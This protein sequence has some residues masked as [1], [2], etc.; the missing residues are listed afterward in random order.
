[1]YVLVAGDPMGFG[2]AVRE[3][4]WSVDPSQPVTGFWPMSAFVDAWVAIPKAT[5]L[6]VLS[7]ATL[8]LLL[9]VVGVF[10]VVSYAVRTRRSE[11]GVRL[12]LGATP[13]RLEREQMRAILP[14]VGL[15]VGGGLVGGVL[16]AGA[17]RGLLYGISP[18]DPLSIGAAIAVM[19]SA[20]LVATYLPA[21]RAGR[22]DPTEVIRAE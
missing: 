5:R 9:S 1:M 8:A 16:A 7:L 13:D 19:A 10:G 11:L 3:A 4:I 12:A 15:G 2:D 14:V 6:L 21:R 17:T 22:V 20:A 18:G